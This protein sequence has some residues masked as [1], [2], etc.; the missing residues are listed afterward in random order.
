MESRRSAKTQVVE[1]ILYC[2]RS[3]RN[4]RIEEQWVKVSSHRRMRMY[5]S[6]FECRRSE[7]GS[8]RS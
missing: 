2:A 4:A 6:S 5:D 3:A 8:L 1:S 7:R